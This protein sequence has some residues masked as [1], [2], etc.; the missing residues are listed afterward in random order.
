MEAFIAGYAYGTTTVI[1]GQPLETIKTLQQAQSCTTSGKNLSS[2]TIASTLWK[3]DGIKG[4]YRGGLPLLVGGG[5]I[6]SF[7]FGFYKESLKFIR[8]HNIGPSERISG[9][10]FQVVMAGLI[11][12]LGRGIAETPFEYIKVR[13]QVQ[14][15]MKITELL[16][17]SKQTLLR[18]SF[19][20]ASFAIYMDLSDMLFPL[21]PFMKGG[22]CSCMAW[23][24]VWPLDVVKSRVQA[25]ITEGGKKE[26]ILATLKALHRSKAL[27]SGLAPGL[28]RSFIANGLSMM[29][30][31]HVETLLREKWKKDYIT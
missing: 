18:N 21:S 5:L 26:S 22:I 29:A 24:T 31:N 25:G 30:Y 28:T 27:Y 15:Q 23:M 6:R 4:F 16:K 20:F 11:G 14:K 9:L 19:L 1:V 10:D 17:G 12:G 2:F 7:Q 3:N 8:D 13:R